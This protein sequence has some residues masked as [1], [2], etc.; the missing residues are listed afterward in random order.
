MVGGASWGV[1]R[2]TSKSFLLQTRADDDTDGGPHPLAHVAG[3]LETIPA[4]NLSSAPAAAPTSTTAANSVTR[5]SRPTPCMHTTTISSCWPNTGFWA[6][7]RWSSSWRPTHLRH[8]WNTFLDKVSDQENVTGP[9]SEQYPG[10]DHRRPER[11]R[12]LVWSHCFLDYNLHMPANLLAAAIVFGL[13]TDPTR[14]KRKRH[15]LERKPSPTWRRLSGWPCRPWAWGLPSSPCP[16]FPRSTIP[17]ARG[18]SCKTPVTFSRRSSRP[19]WRILR[20]RG[21]PRMTA[22]PNCTPTWPRRSMPAPFRRTIRKRRPTF[23]TQAVAEARRA[24]ELAP[25]G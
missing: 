2:L 15:N 22:I 1:H 13:L 24:T 17:N 18:K 20:A 21:W 16:L 11:R 25:C 14:S 10:P 23:R 6:S 12:S 8:G 3:G 7:S 9:A 5:P 19:A 4:C